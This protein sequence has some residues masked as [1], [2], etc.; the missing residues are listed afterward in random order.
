MRRSERTAT[1]WVSS[2]EKEIFR[3]MG[4]QN[5]LVVDQSRRAAL[6]GSST[7]L[8]Y[9]ATRKMLSHGTTEIS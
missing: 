8:L 6:A 1:G 2:L 9:S 5:D 3:R 4:K 7:M